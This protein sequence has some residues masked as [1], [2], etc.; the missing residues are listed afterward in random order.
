VEEAADDTVF[1]FLRQRKIQSWETMTWLEDQVRV[2][3]FLNFNL[4]LHFSSYFVDST[5]YW[6]LQPR[7]SARVSLPA[8]FGLQASYTNMV[9]YIHLLTNSGLGLPTDLWVP[10]TGAIPPQRSRQ[11]SLGLD[12][13]F[14]KEQWSI[15]IEAYYKE[16]RD[17]IDYQTG[18]NF[19]G[20]TDWQDLVEKS[21]IGW[22]SGLELLL[23]KRGGRLSGWIGYTLS[24]TDREFKTINFGQ[25]FP[26]K[27]DRRHDLST[28]LLFK[29]NERWDVS[30][31][32]KYATGNAVTFPEAVY[33]APTSPI[34]D[35]MDL[36]Q[37]QGLDVIIDYGSR[38]NFR[39]PDY[40]RLD[41]NFR[42]HKPVKF[43]EMTLN[44]GVYNVYNR[45]NP[46]FLFLRADYS[47][48]PNSPTVKVRKMSLL[49]ILPELNFGFKF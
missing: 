30:A 16:M 42:F 38:N 17:L 11:V 6:S 18:V 7:G 2:G 21:G 22:S 37:G 36:N 25:P 33:Y 24:R 26:Y 9:Q 28:A 31:N 35:F 10:A 4:G 40:H 44:F 43:G 49:P 47:E 8:G 48:D 34:L 12:K 13:K 32:W 1:T 14:G 39:L 3:K 46:Y 15:G 27:Y 29:L 19:L 41:V 5:T 45:R 23:Q 20:N